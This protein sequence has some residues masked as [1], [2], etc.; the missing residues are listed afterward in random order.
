MV[1]ASGDYP[2]DEPWRNR[3]T[4]TWPAGLESSNLTWHAGLKRSNWTCHAGPERST[5]HQV[6]LSN[7]TYHVGPQHKTHWIVN[8]GEP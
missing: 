1:E 2:P 8:E 6:G 5:T 7:S 3:G 4:S